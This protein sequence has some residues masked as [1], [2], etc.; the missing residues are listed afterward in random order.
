[1]SVLQLAERT[2]LAAN[3]I[4]RALAPNGPAP[5]NVANA[6]LLT[7]TLTA[8]GVTFLPAEGDLGSGARLTDASAEPFTRRRRKGGANRDQGE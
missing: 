3:T 4:K 1:M 2:G 5:I 7:A 8:A 6:K